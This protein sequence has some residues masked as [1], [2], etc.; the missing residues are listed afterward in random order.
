[1]NHEFGGLWT[2]L[3]LE[4]VKKYLEAYTRALKNQPF[5]LYYIDAFA[6][7]GR[8][9]FKDGQEIEGSAKIALNCNFNNYFF[10]EQKGDFCDDLKHLKE[11]RPDKNILILN[12]DANDFFLKLKVGNKFLRGVIFLDPYSLEVTWETLKNIADKEIFDVW[13]LFP[14]GALNRLLRRD[15]DLDKHSIQII[16]NLL[17]DISWEETFYED[18]PQLSFLG[19]NSQKITTDKIKSVVINRLKSIFPYVSNNS[20]I[21]RNSK[22]APLFLL[23][24]AV[25]NPNPAAYGLAS[26]IADYILLSTK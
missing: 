24:F 17:G 15:G 19:N 21:L 22:N 5:K 2:E 8:V 6:G 9:N 7:N 25:S 13:Y 18:N 3:K 1:M 20:L 16:K 23:C 4:C 12:D 10:I 11:S 26:K 14:I